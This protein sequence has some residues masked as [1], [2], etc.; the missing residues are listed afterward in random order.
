MRVCIVNN[1]YLELAVDQG[2][3]DHNITK[4]SYYLK[5]INVF[6]DN[7]YL[8]GLRKLTEHS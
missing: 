2:P 3:V 1:N 8:P 4:N 7:K 5:K 6:Q